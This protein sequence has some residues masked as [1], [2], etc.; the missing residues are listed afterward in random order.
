MNGI[1]DMLRYL[2][3][4]RIAVAFPLLAA[5]TLLACHAAPRDSAALPPANLPDPPR[6]FLGFD[7]ND[8]PGDA[9][10]KVLRKDFAF[11]GFWLGPPPGE[12][13]SSWS[14]KRGLLH[15]LGYGFLPL[16][17]GPDSTKLKSAGA[18]EKRGAS[19]AKNT[20]L[21]A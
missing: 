3:D 14:G 5:A 8:Y 2:R 4:T 16:Y 12:T 21:A 13:S 1:R 15:S 11:T 6:Y 7:R 17:L 20:A 19:D 18:A 9:A 10:M